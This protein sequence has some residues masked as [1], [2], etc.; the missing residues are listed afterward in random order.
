[1]GC[2]SLFAFWP[3]HPTF[4]LGGATGQLCP[5]VSLYTLRTWAQACGE[6]GEVGP[7]RESA[8]RGLRRL[9]PCHGARWWPG[10]R[11]R[12]QQ[13]GRQAGCGTGG[14]PGHAGASGGLPRV[15]HD[16][17]SGL[18]FHLANLTIQTRQGSIFWEGQF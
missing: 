6:I 11:W 16:P 8:G 18:H 1:M 7:W 4:S 3:L 15:W 17:N 13:S 9:L 2:D 5:S 14:E 10:D 12:L